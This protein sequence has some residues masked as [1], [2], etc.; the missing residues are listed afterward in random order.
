M[1]NVLE[2]LEAKVCEMPDKVA[3]ANE[4]DEITFRELAQC[5]Q[6]A[7][8]FIAVSAEIIGLACLD[9]GENEVV[10]EVAV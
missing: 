9:S 5:A 1:T 2:W 4:R 10:L 3:F 6:A 8:S 7:G